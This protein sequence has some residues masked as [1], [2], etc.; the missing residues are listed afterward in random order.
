[1]SVVRYVSTEHVRRGRFLTH[2]QLERTVKDLGRL[3]PFSVFIIVP[4]GELFLPIALKIFPNLLPSTYEDQ[5]QKDAKSNKLRSTRKDVSQ[6]IR[7]TMKESGIPLS[8]QTRQREEF[9]QFFK[10]VVPPYT[11]RGRQF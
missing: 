4:A 10:K 9:T 3:V 5:S 7:T 2:D 11:F 8:K 6:F 1:V